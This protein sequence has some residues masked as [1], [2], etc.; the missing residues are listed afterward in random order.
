MIELIQY[1]W[2]SFR[3]DRRRS[4]QG[5]KFT[6]PTTGPKSDS[7]TSIRQRIR[8]SH[9]LKRNDET[10]PGARPQE[11]ENPKSAFKE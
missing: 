2:G 6:Q 3:P 1:R 8:E 5:A 4:D 11:L 7:E 9:F 10:A